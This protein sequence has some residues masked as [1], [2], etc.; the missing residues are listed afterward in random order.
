[1][2]NISVAGDYDTAVSWM[3]TYTAEADPN[4][5]VC[6]NCHD[7]Y[8]PDV[9]DE[10]YLEHAKVNRVSRVAMDNAE[11]A[12]NGGQV[13]GETAGAQRDQLCSGCHGG[14]PS[15]NSCTPGW[16]NH[17]IQ[18]RVSEVV[19]EDISAPEPLNGCGW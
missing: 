18:G 7:A 5:D 9:G 15:V 19:W 3:H 2:E 11:R 14:V 1:M 13:F 10:D 4:Q 12:V 17:L 6:Q 16:N 8:T